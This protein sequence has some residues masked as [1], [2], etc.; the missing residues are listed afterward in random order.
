MSIKKKVIKYSVGPLGAALISLV[1]I[2]ILAWYY[3]V[4]DVARFSI[5]QAIIMLYTLVLC[6]GLDQAYIREYYDSK[7]K[8]ILLKNILTGI[9]IPSLV[10][11]I[12]LYVFFKKEITIFLYDQYMS[13]F[14]WL[15]ILSAFF[16]LQIKIISS[17]Q[18]VKEQALLFSLSQFLPKII[19]LIVIL[20]TTFIYGSDFENIL[21][22]QFLSLFLVFICFF[23]IN[24]KDIFI[25]LKQNLDL[26]A[27]KKYYKF[28]FPLILTGGVIWGMKLA[29]R[30]Y[31]KIFSN[32][33]ELGLYSMAISIASGVAIFSSVFNTLWAPLVYKWVNNTEL[34]D[35][36]IINQ[37]ENIAYKASIAVL[38]ITLLILL[39]SRG[40]VWFL[41]VN[42]SHIYVIIPACALAPLLYT[43]SE[44]TGIGINL[45]KKTKYTLYSCIVA[46]IFHILFSVFL[47]PR[48]GA[49][50]AALAGL[51]AFYI[52][53]IMRTFFSN[54]I[55][56][57]LHYNKVF[58]FSLLSFL[59]ASC[60]ILLSWIN[61]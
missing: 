44:I 35:N 25:C 12:F 26:D 33:S 54:R 22:A 49:E 32:L 41:P 61:L 8:D 4:V 48:L 59:L 47:I 9:L 58:F 15:T 52:F 39:V 50:G 3:D 28:G 29:D 43:L 45:M 17:I 42:Y 31:L 1:T 30:F 14:F 5:F 34:K 60:P 13:S 46:I 27:V 16:S 51:M 7:N 36:K 19:F 2:P 55:W 53:F 21:W 40:V 6:F 10:F 20:F 37:V 23:W 18:R 38:I 57:K 24:K 56:V 11:I